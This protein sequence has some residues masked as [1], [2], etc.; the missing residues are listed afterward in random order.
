MNESAI[1]VKNIGKAY[2]LGVF[3]RQTL[4][5]EIQ[6][7]LH[8]VH[9][10]NPADYM[11]KI[12]IQRSEV[13][14]Q[15][16]EEEARPNFLWAL[17]D[18]SFDVQ[19]GEVLGIIGR[20]GAG[21]STLLK[22]LSRITDPTEGEA[23]INGRVGSLLE[24]GTGFHPE[25]TGREN[26]Y[27]NGTILGMR[28]SEV[29]R[30][31]DE[32]VAFAE[33]D[34]FLDTP[35]KRYSSGMYVRLAFAV[36]AHLDPEIL[37]IDEVLAVGDAGFQRKCLGKMSEVAGAGRTILFVSHNMAAIRQLTQRCIVLDD[38]G[39]AF[40][41]DSDDAVDF[42]LSRFVSPENNG[43]VVVTEEMRRGV[44]KEI[45]RRLEFKTIELR[46]G[47]DGIKGI[48][49]EDEDIR[50]LLEIGANK[51]VSHIECVLQIKTVEDVLVTTMTTR[52]LPVNW[53]VGRHVVECRVTKPNLVRGKYKLLA[54][55]LSGNRIP[56]DFLPDAILLEVVV[57]DAGEM[58]ERQ[59][60][61]LHGDIVRLKSQWAIPGSAAGRRE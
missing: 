40:D 53:D 55:V 58:S 17:K 42:Y 47:D 25:L 61:S 31:F 28:K 7:W 9:G 39:K 35:V 59:M 4:S 12:T 60:G 34:Q 16:S 15:K 52:Q 19:S 48:F 13:R 5:E 20:N 6:Y 54:Y 46:G 18:V 27:L 50:I 8:K 44:K 30:K 14:S 29:T 51:Q 38:G 23:I 24:V 1:S 37:L 57:G 32:I 43:S 11:G 22:V 33:I 26:I 49:L 41:G 10:R 3:N 45:Q 21:K 56:E 36:A 2:H